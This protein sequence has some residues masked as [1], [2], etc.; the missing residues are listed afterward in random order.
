MDGFRILTLAFASTAV[1]VCTASGQNLSVYRDFHLGT[2]VTTI[3][4][5]A[6]VS[7]E[8]RVLSQRPVLLQ[9]LMWQPPTSDAQSPEAVRKVVFSFYN[10][11][12][13]RI[14]VDYDPRRTAGMTAADIIEAL[15]KQFGLATLPSTGFLPPARTTIGNGGGLIVSWENADQSV[16]LTSRPPSIFALVIESKRIAALATV[17]AADAIWMERLDA[18]L[19]EAEREQQQTQASRDKE[20][21]ARRANRAA[22]R[23]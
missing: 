7:P 16:S 9:E 3:A 18:P 11:E 2:S 8:P 19:R 23:P 20:E 6:G 10:D 21:A 12:L 22:F 14:V 17:A 4:A 13:F 15:S 1:F 5:Q